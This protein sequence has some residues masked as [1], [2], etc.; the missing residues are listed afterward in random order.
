MNLYKNKKKYK[1]LIKIKNVG[2]GILKVIIES[3][4]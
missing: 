2:N 3:W 4:I 1:I